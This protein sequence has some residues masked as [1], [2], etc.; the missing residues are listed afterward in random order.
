VI[1]KEEIS[2]K[3]ALSKTWSKLST[4]QKQVWL[5]RFYKVAENPNYTYDIQFQ[6]LSFVKDY[7]NFYPISTL[8]IN[9]GYSDLRSTNTTGHKPR[10]LSTR[11]PNFEIMEYNFA[12]PSTRKFIN[13]IDSN[14]LFCDSR[15]MQ[16]YKHKL[17]F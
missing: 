3:L 5:G 6:F 1:K 11:P 12:T 13:L 16:L 15:A 7:E 14:L 4:F 17:K 2:E 9:E 8:V 10:W